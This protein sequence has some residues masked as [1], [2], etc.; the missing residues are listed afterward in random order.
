MSAT[1]TKPTKKSSKLAAES[2]AAACR[3]FGYTPRAD[4][5]NRVAL[6]IGTALDYRDERPGAARPNGRVERRGRDLNSRWASDP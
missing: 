2:E 3:I 1:G 6:L 5:A 4:R